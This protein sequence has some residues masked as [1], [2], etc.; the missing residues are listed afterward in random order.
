LLT[1]E[2]LSREGP[3]EAVCAEYASRGYAGLDIS[4]VHILCIGK[5]RFARVLRENQLYFV[6]K[7]YS[8]GGGCVS[9]P[10]NEAALEAAAVAHP[11]VGR[12]VESHIAVFCAQV[13]ELCGSALLRPLL[14]SISGQSGRD[15][16]SQEDADRFFSAC[17]AVAAEFGV[18]LQHETHRHRILFNPWCARASVQRLPRLNLLADLSHY[19]V[20]CEAPCEDPDL[21]EAIAALIPRV[22]HTH[23]RVGY[24]EGPQV[25]DPTL[26]AFAGHVAGHAAWW[27][28][29]FRAHIAAG[30]K[31]CTVTPEFLPF[32][33]G[34]VGC[35]REGTAKCNL[36]I[37]GVVRK[38]WEEVVE[39]GAK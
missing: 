32:P 28:A 1:L 39:E 13:R 34:P 37:E 20:V 35:L 21:G 11:P 29:I 10:G 33:Y 23:A 22:T 36:F 26:P 5:E 4:S 38:A 12:D 2:E 16:F 25:P 17:E 27:K 15:Y 31:V 14:L 6:G 7:C 8:S 30:K 9:S 24:E 19:C 3:F 18:Q